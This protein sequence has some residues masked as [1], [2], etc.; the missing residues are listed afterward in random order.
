MYVYMYVCS[1]VGTYI[2]VYIRGLPGLPNEGSR[3]VSMQIPCFGFGDFP[4]WDRYD[5]YLLNVLTLMYA[6][7][8]SPSSNS[9]GG[10]MA[11]RAFLVSLL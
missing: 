2:C 11:A 3:Y 4:Y 9:A 1:H 6:L 8:R 10:L 5:S 7:P